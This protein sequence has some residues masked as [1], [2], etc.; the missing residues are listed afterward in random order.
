MVIKMLKRSIYVGRSYIR[1][2]KPQLNRGVGY[3]EL[4]IGS[5]MLVIEK[6]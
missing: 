1:T 3:L 6:V 4:F 2:D 5:Y